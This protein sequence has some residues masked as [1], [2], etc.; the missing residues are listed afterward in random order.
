[1]TK[2]QLA[3]FR[4]RLYLP[5]PDDGPRGDEPPYYRPGRDSASTST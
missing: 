5:I 3:A 1:M 2:D 4:D